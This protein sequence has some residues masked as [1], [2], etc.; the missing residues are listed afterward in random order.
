MVTDMSIDY[1][2]VKGILKQ[3]ISLL[4]KSF[5]MYPTLSGLKQLVLVLLKYGFKL[6]KLRKSLVR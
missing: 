6:K 1:V 5:C 4:L 3:G 2:S